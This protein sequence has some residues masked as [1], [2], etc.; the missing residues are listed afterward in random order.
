MAVST[1]NFNY[2]Q[3]SA[4]PMAG[5]AGYLDSILYACLVTG[6][7]SKTVSSISVSSNVA[8][9]TTSTSH[10]LTVNDIIVIS[11]ANESVFNNEFRIKAITSST[12]FTVDLITADGSATGTITCKIAPLGYSRVYQKTNV[13]VYRAPAGTRFY[14]RVDDTQAQYAT[15]SAY[16][17]MTTVDA[18]TNLI[19]TVYWKKS[20]VSDTTTREWYLIGNNKTF[21]LFS[22]WI[23]GIYSTLHAGYMFGDINSVKANDSYA[24]MLIGHSV[25]NPGNPSANQ[26]FSYITFSTSAAYYT[27]HYLARAATGI[28]G[29]INC[30]KFSVANGQMGYSG[31]MLYPNPADNGLHLYPVDVG[32]VAGP[33]Y[34]GRM[35]G[36]YVP[37]EITN[38][39]F[40]SNDR[41]VVINGKT[42]MAIKV[43]CVNNLAGNCFFDLGDW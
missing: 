11:G 6:Y 3:A 16:E 33:V 43:N 36:L 38:G 18:G 19:G 26:S 37:L 5:T 35:A 10:N 7:N 30:F 34:R 2:L 17:S 20:N 42:Y 8:T 24:S 14:L 29:G 39:A 40:A 25:S 31:G 4:S 21:Y 13:S 41:S 32:E 23:S 22:A 15:V 28:V 1:K 9:I 12:A 27:G